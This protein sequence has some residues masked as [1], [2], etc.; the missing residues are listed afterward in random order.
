MDIHFIGIAG[1]SC[2]GKTELGR[3]L[4]SRLQAP[5]IA[6]DSYYRDL[7]HLPFEERARTN[8][9]VPSAVEHELLIRHL[10]QLDA[11]S[12]VAVPCYDFSTHQR[13][14]ETVTISPG[15]YILV[16]G[17]FTLVWEELRAALATAVYVDAS[18]ET[19][20]QR[21][22]ARDVAE[23]QRTR[24]SVLAQFREQVL[25]MAQRHVLPTRA[26]ADLVVSGTEPLSQT[27]E[28]VLTAVRNRLASRAAH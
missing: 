8:F 12:A 19:C 17:L 3:W 16:E 22:L 25:P 10:E 21:R 27:G 26:F 15:P 11:G 9:D 7:P 4:C 2:S 28:A 20:L 18:A 1:P 24:E 6:M 5:L 13:A 23:R 14:G